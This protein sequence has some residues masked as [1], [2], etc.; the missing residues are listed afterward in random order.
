MVVESG[1]NTDMFAD[2]KLMFDTF[3]DASAD[4][5]GTSIKIGYP[6]G[7]GLTSQRSGQTADAAPFHPICCGP[8]PIRISIQQQEKQ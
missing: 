5:P 7:T 3:F 4:V 6:Q 8:P 1:T 2:V